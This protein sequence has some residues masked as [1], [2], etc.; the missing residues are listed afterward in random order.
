[1]SVMAAFMVPHPPMIIPEVG[2]GSE[3]Q[4]RETITAYERV[5]DEVA[6]LQPDTIIITSPHSVMYADYFHISP[7]NKATGSFRQFRAPGVRFSERYDTVL[8]G[9]ICDLA[10]AENFP[11]GTL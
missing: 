6:A 3:E 11:A 5:A 2:R 4:I 7:G 1:M 9:R 8:V 10:E